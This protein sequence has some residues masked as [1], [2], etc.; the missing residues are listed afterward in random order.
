MCKQKNSGSLALLLLS[1]AR[2][3]RGDKYFSQLYGHSSRHPP[4]RPIIFVSHF[5][6]V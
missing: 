3:S 6:I 4:R 2:E 1:S 5:Y